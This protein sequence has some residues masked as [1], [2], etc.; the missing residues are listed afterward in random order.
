[1]VAAVCS[2]GG[3]G[4]ARCF[5]VS[6][7]PVCSIRNNDK[8][9]CH[10]MFVMRITLYIRYDYIRHTHQGETAHD[11]RIIIVKRAGYA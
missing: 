2:A 9:H 3:D 8:P 11:S 10:P 5:V 1:M 6:V 7:V 4:G